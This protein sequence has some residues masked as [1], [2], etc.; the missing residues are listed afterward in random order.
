MNELICIFIHIITHSCYLSS[1]YAILYKID[2]LLNKLFFLD[3]I[4]RLSYAQGKTKPEYHPL[5]VIT[6]IFLRIFQL[7][8]GV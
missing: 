1:I 7:Y 4:L 6:F 3:Y 8:Q 2:S 5:L